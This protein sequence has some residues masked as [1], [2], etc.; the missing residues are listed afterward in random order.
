MDPED[1]VQLD[2]SQH[3]KSVPFLSEATSGDSK[4]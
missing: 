3:S 1:K 2:T 4:D